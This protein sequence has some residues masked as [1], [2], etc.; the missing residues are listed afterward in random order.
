[1]IRSAAIQVGNLIKNMNLGFNDTNLFINKK[2]PEEMLQNKE[3]PMIQINTLPTNS[4]DY[5]SN[6]KNFETVSCQVNVLVATNR[7]VEK[8]HNLIEKNLST[9][10]FECFFDTQELD[11]NYEVQRLILRFNKTQNIKEIF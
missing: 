4:N 10:Q 8:Y 7:E 6:R 2:I 11:E 3:F 5:A 1:M 9:H